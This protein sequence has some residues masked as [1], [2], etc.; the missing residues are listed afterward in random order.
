MTT[1]ERFSLGSG[2]M[3]T[4][5]ALGSRGPQ[6]RS[7]LCCRD[8]EVMELLQWM[9]FKNRVEDAARR[10]EVFLRDAFSVACSQVRKMVQQVDFNANGTMD[11]C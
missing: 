11:L 9:G 1:F 8:M 5:Q 10:S 4:L 7:S 6:G 2:E 3:P